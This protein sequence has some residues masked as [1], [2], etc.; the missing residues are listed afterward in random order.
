MDKA[1]F[2]GLFTGEFVP[3]PD[4]KYRYFSSHRVEMYRVMRECIEPSGPEVP[5]YLCME[6]SHIWRRVFGCQPEDLPG[7][8]PLFGPCEGC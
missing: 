2:G 8:A 1:F 7:L 3:C 5:L 6:A 4:G